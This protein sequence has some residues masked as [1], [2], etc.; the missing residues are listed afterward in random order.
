MKLPRFWRAV[1]QRL[2]LFWDTPV[3][4]PRCVL[5]NSKDSLE[6]KQFA[7]QSLLQMFCS[8][9]GVRKLGLKAASHWWQC[10][11]QQSRPSVLFLAADNMTLVPS[12]E[13]PSGS[14]CPTVLTTLLP[15][16]YDH[17]LILSWVNNQTGT[18]SI[19]RL[20]QRF[21]RRLA[22][23]GQDGQRATA[24]AGLITGIP[25]YQTPGGLWSLQAGQ[26]LE[27]ARSPD[28]YNQLY[29]L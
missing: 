1:E 17:G 9:D 21:L 8:E 13:W 24:K 3:V 22:G 10:T 20:T 11:S 7:P 27:L 14:P 29:Y 28:S 6:W 23:S 19:R 15:L 26:S 12:L 2:R 4:V 25:G 5:W 18:Y 16:W